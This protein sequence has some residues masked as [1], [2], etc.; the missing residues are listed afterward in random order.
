MSESPVDV[1]GPTAS[2]T[3]LGPQHD[4]RGRGSTCAREPPRAASLVDATKRQTKPRGIVQRRLDCSELCFQRFVFCLRCWWFSGRSEGERGGVRVETALIGLSEIR[5][6][7][8]SCEHSKQRFSFRGGERCPRSFPNLSLDP[9]DSSQP[10]RLFVVRKW[11]SENSSLGF[12][13]LDSEVLTPVERSGAFFAVLNPR[14]K[15]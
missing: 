8:K 15:G 13:K 10:L 4:A 7:K 3:G 5:K 12:P 6:S 1:M 11:C 2:L 14:K 9:A